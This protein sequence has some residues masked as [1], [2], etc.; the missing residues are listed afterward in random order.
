MAGEF[1]EIYVFR[2][3]FLGVCGGMSK[4]VYG[5]VFCIVE[6]WNNLDVY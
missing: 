4:D 1:E 3:F 2:D 6:N 5:S